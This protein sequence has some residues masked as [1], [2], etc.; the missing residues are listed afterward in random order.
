MSS[1]YI[2]TI[3]KG[4]DRSYKQTY[5][6][7]PLLAGRIFDD[8]TLTGRYRSVMTWQGY[9]RPFRRRPGELL[10]AATFGQ[11]YGNFDVVEDWAMYDA[12]PMEDIQDDLYNNLTTQ[13][14]RI[15]GGM[16]SSFKTHVDRACFEFIATYILGSASASGL[17]T[18]DGYS[19]CSTVHPYS[20]MNATTF[21]NRPTS[22]MNMSILAAD[23]IYTNLATQ[24]VESGTQIIENPLACVLIH[25]SQHRVTTQVFRGDWERATADRNMN[26]YNLKNVDILETAYFSKSG[27]TGTN[28]AWL[29]LGRTRFLKLC[30]RQQPQK[31]SWM[32]EMSNS[33]VFAMMMRY[34]ITFDNWRGLVGSVGT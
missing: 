26:V 14:P 7:I 30:T 34:L 25:P 4:I 29:G 11:S 1:E 2:S 17:A 21:G 20:R 24:P 12:L 13:G 33:A 31:R 15:G 10:G 28:N 32:H 9:P 18:Y 27:A 23:F 3:S 19:G 22:E 16:A 8:E 5:N 6:E